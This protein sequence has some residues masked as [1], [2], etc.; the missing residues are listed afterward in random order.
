[1]QVFSVG[2][3]ARQLEVRPSRVTQLFYEGRVRQDRCPVVAGRRL[4]PADMVDVIAMALRRKGIDVPDAN[5]ARREVSR[6][7]R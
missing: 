5:G 6:C 4:I 1:M 3:V 2:D 7:V